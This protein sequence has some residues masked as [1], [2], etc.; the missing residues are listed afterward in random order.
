M[1][2]LNMY[3]IKRKRTIDPNAPPRPNLLSHEKI[4]K[5]AK[6]VA[7]RQAQQIQIL[8]RQVSE[9]TNKVS[10]QTAYLNALHQ[11]LSQKKR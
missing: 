9:L 11:T 7:E 8:Q 3:R 2:D 10:N 5:D 6:T 1:A 4:L